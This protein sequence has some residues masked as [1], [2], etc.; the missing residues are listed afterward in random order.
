MHISDGSG[1]KAVTVS[2]SKRLTNYTHLNYM[3][4]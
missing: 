2:C 4:I 1:G 3:S